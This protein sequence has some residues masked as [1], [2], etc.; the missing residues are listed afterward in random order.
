MF[1]RIPFFAAVL[2]ALLALPFAG[3]EAAEKTVYELKRDIPY[4]AADAG[5]D[6]YRR[7]RCKSD[8]SHVVL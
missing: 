5:A 8:R 6:S 7:G 3:M 1:H 2:A 4:P